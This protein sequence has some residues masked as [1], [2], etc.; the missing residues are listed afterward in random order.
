V[1]GRFFGVN[2]H[3][4]LEFGIKNGDGRYEESAI[5]S[6]LPLRSD[7]SNHRFYDQKFAFI[8]AALTDYTQAWCVW[9]GYVIF[10]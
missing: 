3:A 4:E 6:I 9:N 1:Q 5:S 8:A 2:F 7:V 10:L